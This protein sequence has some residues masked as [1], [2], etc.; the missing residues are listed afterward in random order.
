MDKEKLQRLKRS[1]HLDLPEPAKDPSPSATPD[2]LDPFVRI[3]GYKAR[4]SVFLRELQDAMLCKSASLSPAAR[5]TTAYSSTNEDSGL[6]N[7]ASDWEESEPEEGAAALTHQQRPT[8]VEKEARDYV[9]PLLCR[10]NASISVVLS[11]KDALDQ[12]DSLHKLVNQFMHLQDQNL[13]MTR[14]VKTTNTLLG[15]KMVQNQVS[16]SAYFNPY[17]TD[18]VFFGTFTSFNLGVFHK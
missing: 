14:A 8:S 13:R 10:A 2:T 12:L 1:F 7:R 16:E 11:T 17:R 4:E 18:R 5:D 6:G 3:E 15:L 9:D